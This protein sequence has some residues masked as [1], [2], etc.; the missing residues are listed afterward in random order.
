MVRLG[1]G[2]EEK[3]YAATYRSVREATRAELKPD[4]TWLIAAHRLLRRHG[5]ELCKRARPLCDRCPATR[6]CAYFRLNEAKA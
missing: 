2:R 1:Y 3:A 5:Q 6:E 4:F